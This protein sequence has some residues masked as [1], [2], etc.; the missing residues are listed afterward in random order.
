MD[1]NTNLD[2][3]ETVA[4][5]LA[6]A[7]QRARY[8]ASGRGQCNWRGRWFFTVTRHARTGQVSIAARFWTSSKADRVISSHYSRDFPTACAELITRARRYGAT[9]AK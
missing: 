8:N 5:D 6:A 7:Y 2:N 9:F 1:T 4:I 3:L